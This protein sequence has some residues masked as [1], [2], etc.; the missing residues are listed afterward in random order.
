VSEADV[1]RVLTQVCSA[2]AFLEHE[3][4]VHRDIA[5]RNVLVGEDLACVKLGDLGATRVLGTLLMMMMID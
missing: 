4:V 3:H 5:A 1:V 2:L